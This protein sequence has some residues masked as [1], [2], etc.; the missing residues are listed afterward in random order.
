[1]R[2]ALPK[3]SRAIRSKNF[4]VVIYTDASNSGWGATNGLDNVYGFWD[5]SQRDFHINYKELLA[6]KFGLDALADDVYDC[7]I[8][9]RIDSTT[10]IS[11][12]NRK[13][14]VRFSKFHELA[15]VI[16]QWAETRQVYLFASY[17]SSAENK[18]ADAL[19]RI[20]ND[21]IEWGL[22][23]EFF[24]SI[25]EVFGMPNIDLF[26]SSY[27]TK[28]RNYVSWKR[29]PEALVVDAFTIKWTDLNFYAFPPFSLILK[30]LVKI[31]NDKASGILVVPYWPGQPWWPFFMELLISKTL[32]FGPDDKL[33]FSSCRRKSHPQ[34]SHLRLI[35]GIVSGQLS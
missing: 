5:D 22:N 13:G 3:A 4:E 17:I 14:G 10:A 19:S 16:C 23:D 29:D 7:Q 30:T 21:D 9:L 32:I 33:L 15:R 24:Q 27:N 20:E 34:S 8:L 31:K 11:Y 1:M 35:S 2:G 25:V 18:E 26:A 28:C 6:V 12:V